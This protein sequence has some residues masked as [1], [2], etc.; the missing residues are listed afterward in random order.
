MGTIYSSCEI[1]IPF[2]VVWWSVYNLYEL[3]EEEGGEI[4]FTYP[5][6]VAKKELS[7]NLLFTCAYVVQSSVFLSVVTYLLLHNVNIIIIINISSQI[8]FFSALSFTIMILIR[9]S[10][11]SAMIAFVYV[12]VGLFTYGEMLGKTNIFLYDYNSVDTNLIVNNIVKC[13]FF[14]FVSY[15]VGY[16]LLDKKINIR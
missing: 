3:R 6:N 13:L 7:K 12:C 8:L 5:I 4:F 1:S 2:F 14:S 10:G 11:W 15:I 9:D 16:I